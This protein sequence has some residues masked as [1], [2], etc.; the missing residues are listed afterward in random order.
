MI[1]YRYIESRIL[2]LFKMIQDLNISL[3]QYP[4]D[5]DGI[6]KLFPNIK[7]IS[8]QQFARERNL[9]LLEVVKFCKS[10]TGC[11]HKQGNN[12]MIM[13]NCQQPLGRIN[14]T[15]A[16]ELGHIL[17]NHFDSINNFKIAENK[18]KSHIE[19]E[20]DYFA[21][22]LLAPMSIIDTMNISSSCEIEFYFDLSKSA[23]EV[24][25]SKYRRWKANNYINTFDDEILQLFKQNL[26]N[27]I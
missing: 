16:H 5:I 19:M 24:M 27:R 17:L 7:T 9:S 8:Y 3:L 23:S 10:D 20:A 1:R 14:W 11:A 2:E 22:V 12:F 15:Y 26:K 18:G 21:S 13:Y 4:L 25:F 6:I